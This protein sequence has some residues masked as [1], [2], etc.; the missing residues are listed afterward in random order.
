MVLLFLLGLLL[1]AFAVV[2]DLQNISPVTVA[3][4][5]WQLQGSLAL[6]LAFA[7]LLGAAVALLMVIP[8]FISNYFKFKKLQKE[9]VVLAEDLRKQKELTV[10]AKKTPPTAE[11][12]AHIDKG[13]IR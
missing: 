5:Q 7:F 3:F 13:V 4:F 9:N 1:G 11:E 10:F 2:F 6:V 8:E 12:L